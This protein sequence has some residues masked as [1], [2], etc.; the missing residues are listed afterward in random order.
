MSIQR[1]QVRHEIIRLAVP[2]ILSSLM[3]RA[4]SIVDVFLVGGLGAA[5]I[6]A[7]GISQVLVFMS[8]SVVWGFSSGVTV[9]V[10][11]LWGA[12]RRQEA[13]MIAFQ[14]VL[15]CFLLSIVIGLLG[16]FAGPPVARFLGVQPDVMALAGPYLKIIFL[17]FSFTAVVNVLCNIFY[18]IG[19]TR[20]PFVSVLIVNVLHALIAYP[21]IYGSW[22]A[23]RLGVEGAAIAI[24]IS[25]FVGACVML[26][27]LYRR[28]QLEIGPFRA[29][30]LRQVFRIGLPVF[31]DRALQQAGQA[32]YLK[33]ILIYGTAAYAAHQVG[34]AIESFSF[35]PGFG[36]AI[37]ATTAVGQ[38]LGANRRDRA[39]LANWEAN[40][41]AVMLMAGM[42][43]VFYFFP[44]LLLRLFT[45]DAEVIRLGTLFLKIVAGLQIPLAIS[46]VL[47]GSLKGAG[48]TRYLL[49]TTIIGS[50]VVRVPLAYLF[51]HVL[52]WGL[53]FVWG[54]MIVDWVVRMSLLLIRY[55][56]ERWHRNA[57][58]GTEMVH[59]SL[60]RS[61]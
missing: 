12:K 13:S 20:T 15:F 35:M 21:L 31:A 54:V 29:V 17:V 28:G 41:F 57:A 22:G 36:I 55:R 38:S 18:G 33:M 27:T 3:Q 9:V 53:V 50:W 61:A 8:M 19:D 52:G 24:G 48:D 5:A 23:P 2:A 34:L 51:S 44:Y 56:S 37:A 47:S 43:I 7:V 1:H 40:R 26:A 49:F 4:V 46:M 30:L 14:S 45:S 42:G 16:L 60:D 6:A 11:Q 39:N 10:A 32:F 59:E 58:L 25:E